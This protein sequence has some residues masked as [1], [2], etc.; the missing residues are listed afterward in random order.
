MSTT[1]HI[2]YNGKKYWRYP[3]SKRRQLRVYFW[4]HGKWKSPP[5]ALHRQIWIDNFGPIVKGYV[6]HHKDGNTF[7]NQLSNLE[8]MKKGYHA[9]IHATPEMRKRSS[10]NIKKLWENGVI[11]KA[12]QP[13]NEMRHQRHLSHHK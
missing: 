4:H 9:S 1:E 8:L 7:N 10:E 11:Q 3:E 12:L 13:Y 6:V 5:I 2:V